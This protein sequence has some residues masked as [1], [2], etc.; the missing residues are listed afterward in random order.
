MR[1]IVIVVGKTGQG[2]T[3][4]TKQYLNNLKRIIILDPLDEYRGQEY[5]ELSQMIEHMQRYKMYCVKS[6]AI[7]D[8]DDLCKISQSAGNLH[9]VI[10]EA[11]RSIPPRANLPESVKDLIYRGRHQNVSIIAVAQRASSINIALR[12]QFTKI[13][14]FWQTEP[15]DLT[16]LDN[17]S[18]YPVSE[19]NFKPY[20]YLEI[21]PFGVTEKNT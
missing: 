19:Y 4:W 10:E 8:L 15:A 7:D 12:S 18:G 5:Y 1:E 3:T 6:S 2:K 20:S 16:W 17:V 11:Q 14:A 9:F 21:T 13:I